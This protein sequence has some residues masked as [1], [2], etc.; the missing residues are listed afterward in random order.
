MSLRIPRAARRLFG[1]NPLNW[2]DRSYAV[3][4]FVVASFWVLSW[5]ADLVPVF[6]RSFDLHD[7]LI[8]HPHGKDQVSSGLNNTIALWLPILIVTIVGCF[9][10][11]FMEIHH[12]IISVCAGRGLARLITELLKHKIGRLRPDFLAR[13]RWGEALQACTG[14]KASI[15]DGRKSF[16]SGHSS[17]AFAG[18][19]FLALWLAG[20]TAAWCF[21]VPKPTASL[22]S[23]RM[24]WLFITFLPLSWASFVAITRVEDYRHHKEDV[25]VGS[26]IGM[27]SSAICYLIF[28]PNPFS[29]KNFAD[30]RCGQPRMLYDEEFGR[31]DKNFQLTRMEE[32]EAEV[33]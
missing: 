3:D 15:L 18:M 22:L 4:W 19:T 7:P 25:I 31:S 17:T 27:F 28:W 2:L 11:S 30:D 21:N 8:S 12:G 29:A 9:R 32:D 23:T 6:E 33:V 16:P 24:G 14:E 20:Q 26:L 10:K 1:Q 13:C 5:F